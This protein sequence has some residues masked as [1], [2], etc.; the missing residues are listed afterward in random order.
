MF[1]FLLIYSFIFDFNLFYFIYFLFIFYYLFIF[2]FYFL[3]YFIF[4]G[5]ATAASGQR[6]CL[7][8]HRRNFAISPRDGGLWVVRHQYAATYSRRHGIYI[9]TMLQ[10]RTKCK[11]KYHCGNAVE[12]SW[13]CKY[14]IFRCLVNYLFYFLFF[15]LFYF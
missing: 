15:I 8:C 6:P 3:F 5:F 7:A 4:K 12:A 1:Y 2:I 9:G 10:T 14:K 13:T 11:F